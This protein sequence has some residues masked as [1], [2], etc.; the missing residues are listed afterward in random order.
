MLEPIDIVWQVLCV[1]PRVVMLHVVVIFELT[2]D[3]TA[4]EQCTLLICPIRIRIVAKEVRAHL[5]IK[6]GDELLRLR[7]LLHAIIILL[8]AVRMLIEQGRVLHVL[9]VE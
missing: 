5:S 7:E 2:D 4:E 8:Q 1:Q 3:A 6:V 9:I